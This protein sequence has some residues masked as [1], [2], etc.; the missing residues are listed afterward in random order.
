[1][2][3]QIT[4]IN[5]VGTKRA[6]VLQNVLTIIIAL[7]GLILTAG[8]IFSGDVSNVKEQMFV[9]ETNGLIIENIIAV[10]ITTPFFFFGFDVIPQAAEEIKVP[11]KKLGKLMMLSIILAVVF[12]IMVVISVG[13]VMN[14]S[15]IA[16]SME[17]TGLVSA[18]AMAKAFSSEMMAKVLIIGGLCGIIT[19]WNSKKL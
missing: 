19:S 14:A 1:M 17:T 4:V 5:I 7:V 16:L 8:S 6:A 2:I 11:L 9:G 3:T 18:D 10:A 13:Y 12:Y 15:D